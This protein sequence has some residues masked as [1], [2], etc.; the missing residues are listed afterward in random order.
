MNTGNLS[1]E[2]IVGLRRHI[3]GKNWKK[4]LQRQNVSR[5]KMSPQTKCLRR[6]NVSGDKMIPETICLRR[7]FILDK[8]ICLLPTKCLRTHNN[9]SKKSFF[10]VS[11][12]VQK[13]IWAH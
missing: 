2:T 12:N 13:P 5:D 7:P 6:Q 1:P 9:V 4:C 10:Y 11:K 3:V 8:T